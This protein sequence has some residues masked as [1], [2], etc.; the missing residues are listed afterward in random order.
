MEI[1]FWGTRGSY[2]VP[3]HGT[4]VYGGNTACHSVLA[5]DRMIIIDAG[6]GIINLGKKL[7]EG[8]KPLNLALFLSHL[9]IDH[10][11]GLLYFRPN[12]RK[13]TNLHIFGPIDSRGSVKTTLEDLTLP[14]SH[15]ISINTMGMNF[16]CNSITDG[17]SII[18]RQGAAN[19][20]IMDPAEQA[21]SEDVVIKTMFNNR[22]P[23]DGV[24]NFRIEHKN[25]AYVY[26]TDV[27]GDEDTG[28]PDLIRFA[29]GADLMAHDGQYTSAAYKAVHRGWGHSTAAMAV[30]TAQMAGVKQLA[31]IHHEPAHD[32][33]KLAVMEEETKRL[34][35]N[36]FFAKEGQVV[37][38]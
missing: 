20:V 25:K 16:T 2:P 28:D 30:K 15:P 4:L 21:E 37:H 29:A 38:L 10:T 8:T 33:A 32:D 18:W 11:S 1:A 35:A 13:T 17:N 23:V 3:G 9:H 31:L 7:T 12:F 14:P 5:G 22:H 19:P 36:S 34:F 26:A 27:E 6:T 24:L